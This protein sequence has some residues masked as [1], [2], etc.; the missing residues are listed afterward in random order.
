VS[1]SWDHWPWSRGAFAFY[2]PGQF[3][4]MHRDVIAPEWDRR[5]H[6]AGEHCSRTHTWIEGA[7]ESAR[8]AVDNIMKEWEKT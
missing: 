8:A 4:T 7:L 2:M 3:A 1:W 5:V 6:F